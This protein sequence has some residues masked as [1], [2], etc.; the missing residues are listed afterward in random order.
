MTLRGLTNFTNDYTQNQVTI[1]FDS[2]VNTSAGQDETT[3]VVKAKKS[4]NTGVAIYNI[5]FINTFVQTK[6]FAALACDFYGA[7]IA[8]YGCAFY[9]FQ[10]TVLLNKGT[11]ILSNCYIE[12]SVDFVWGFSTA[13]INQCKIAINTPGASIAA[14]SRANAVAP[15]GYVFNACYVT[16]T[17]S[18]GSTPGLSYLGRPYSNFS[19]A[20][21]TNSYLDSS[22]NPAGWSIWQANNPQTSNVTF[23]EYNNTGP[24]SLGKRATFSKHLT[25][26]EAAAYELSAFI[27]DTSWIDMAQ[28]NLAPSWK[29][30]APTYSITV[31]G[32]GLTPSRAFKK[33]PFTVTANAAASSSTVSHPMSGSVP[34][35]DAVLVA[36]DSPVKG[37]FTS[38]SAA[39]ASLPNDTTP[40]TI[41]IYPG[42]Y[43]EQFN[44]NRPGPVTIIGFSQNSPGQTYEHN[45]VSI[46]YSRGL[47]LVSP[48]PSGH[49]DQE[50]AILTTTS[51]QISFY[52]INFINTDNLDGSVAS[53]V[54]LAGSTYGDRIALYGCS[55][56]GWQDTLLTGST[57]GY[58]YYES[59]YIEGAI[60]FIWG[61]SA[62][63][64]K[65]CVIGAKRA[66]SAITAQ[67]R[68]GATSI[69][70][71]VFDQC[72]FTQAEDQKTNLDQT[73]YLGRPYSAFAKVV[74]KKSYLGS[75]VNPS[76]WKPWSATDPR[77]S[78]VTF[79]EYNNTGPG[80]WESNAAARKA[81]GFATAATE[82]DYPFES[83]FSA[84]GTGWI[85]LTFYDSIVTPTAANVNFSQYITPTIVNTTSTNAAPTTTTFATKYVPLPTASANA[86]TTTALPA[87][88][89][90]TEP[91]S[92]FPRPGDY[93]V[94]Q[95]LLDRPFVYPTIQKALAALPNDNTTATLFIYPGT[96]NVTQILL[97]RPGTTTFRGYSD[98]PSSYKRNV[99]T[100]QNDHSVDTQAKN[101]SNSDSATIHS[102]SPLVNV[103]NINLV[104]NNAF[105]PTRNSIAS[106]A[107]AIG[108]NG[109]VAFYACQIRAIHDTL[110]VAA[111]TNVFA[112]GTYVQGGID[113]IRNAGSVYLLAS[114]IAPTVAG[115]AIT[116]MQ[117]ASAA[118]P[119]GAVF[120]QCNVQAPTAANVSDGS[121]FLG[122][123]YSRFSRVAY[124]QSYLGGVISPA[125]WEAWRPADPR[126][127][128]VEFAEY[129]NFGAGAA[130][131]GRVPFSH[132]AT[133]EEAGRV[134]LA[135]F[136]A[137]TDVIDFGA[138]RR[139][140]R[141]WRG[142]SGIED[143]E[144]DGFG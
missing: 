22:I 71:Y 130:L 123:P 78:N 142:R 43:M 68:A 109:N 6:N 110:D 46:R 10:D 120:D 105:R 55:L 16:Q 57:T 35:P 122:R 85:D 20:V 15:G 116:A 37:A 121:V 112:H 13:F 107:F 5:N 111:G 86:S 79:V 127:S 136:L 103:Y 61:Y 3:P 34:P 129:K 18:Y 114:D 4:D 30:P 41:F 56:V 133:D 44:I 126:T 117:R 53:Y 119:G 94:S 51:N 17:S 118:S 138:W 31:P 69:G 32:R 19:I 95:A 12:G 99:V 50:T 128:G 140:C 58:Q 21:Y 27:G 63:Y 36:S 125:G 49:H 113:F 92:N 101:A 80:N 8:A 102:R 25:T 93:V 104:N 108:N 60:D 132:E 88:P 23:A 66:S 29:F 134:E 42:S 115:S 33:I 89:T 14:Q 9:G 38:L 45:T 54:T 87:A 1:T 100:I 74:I 91:S 73:V 72:L 24:G 75:V 97:T 48:I 144:G 137:S 70:G 62:A 139:R 98:L 39:L 52:N 82:D 83:F 59:C 7:N 96:Y 11:Q 28:Y 65:G 141:L 47:S 2:G 90:S 40:Q 135:R 77:T 76:G 81:T 143:V 84:G 26:S 67:S 124:V 106:L 64:F 131:A